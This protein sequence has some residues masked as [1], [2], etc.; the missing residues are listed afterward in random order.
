MFVIDRWM[1]RMD[2]AWMGA[3]TDAT[4]DAWTVGITVIS[5]R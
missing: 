1:G 4:D 2:N 5:C 3:M